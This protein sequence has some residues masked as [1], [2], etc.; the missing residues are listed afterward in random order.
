MERTEKFYRE[1]IAKG[2]RSLAKEELNLT[3]GEWEERGLKLLKRR[4]LGFCGRKTVKTLDDLTEA[5]VDLHIIE[6]KEG[7]RFIQGLYGKRFSYIQLG[8]GIPYGAVLEFSK[9]QDED[10]NEACRI[11]YETRFPE[12]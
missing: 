6:P 9:A 3:Q 5:L 10:G 4:I 11:Y 2:A 8:L 7:E 12:W 1:E